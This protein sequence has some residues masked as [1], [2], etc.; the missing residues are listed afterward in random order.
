MAYLSLQQQCNFQCA[1]RLAAPWLGIDMR[2]VSR[3]IELWVDRDHSFPARFISHLIPGPL[4]FTSDRRTG[5]R[6]RN[7]LGGLLSEHI[8]HAGKPFLLKCSIDCTPV[9]DLDCVWGVG[10]M[11]GCLHGYMNELMI[12]CVGWTAD[13]ML[14]SCL[15]A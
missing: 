7:P 8:G 5:A 14:G 3:S 1:G 4:H 11:D 2:T 9:R 10:C 15:A 13:T 6:N 12:V